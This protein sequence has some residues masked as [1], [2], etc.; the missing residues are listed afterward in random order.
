[1]GFV[2]ATFG[3]LVSGGLTLIG[4]R[5]TLDNQYKK[6]FID[7]YPK[8]KMIL[9]EQ[10][11]EMNN[12]IKFIEDNVDREIDNISYGEFEMKYKKMCDEFYAYIKKTTV[13]NGLVYG[14][15]KEF[16][17]QLSEIK[18]CIGPKFRRIDKITG[19]Q[20]I[21]GTCALTEK[22]DDYDMYLKNLKKLYQ[23][24]N[25]QMESQDRKYEKLTGI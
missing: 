6:E 9:D 16:Q 21:T 22:K 4:V 13:I 7:L 23:E 2:A 11:E 12:I 24:I 10:L 20:I 18:M 25:K 19:E 8:R 14:A 5:A 1:M 17:K 15:S 3:G